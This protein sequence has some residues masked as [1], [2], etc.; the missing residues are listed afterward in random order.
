MTVF[1]AVV[2]VL[3]CALFL[4]GL[5]SSS[6]IVQASSHREAPLIIRDPLADDTD[7]YFFVSPDRPDMV[8]V[9][10]NWLP[11]QEPAGGPNFYPFDDNVLYQL[12]FDNDGDAVL[13]IA[14]EFRFRT[15]VINPDTFLYTTGRVD[16]NTLAGLNVRQTYSVTAVVVSS[17]RNVT[18][19]TFNRFLLADNLPTPP[20]NVGPRSTP[21]YETNYAERAIRNVP[22]AGTSG[23]NFFAGQ[24]DEGFFFDL[25]SGFD[26]FGLRPL[27]SLH[28]ISLPN[29]TGK[30]GLAG[31]NVN[32][33][34][35]QLPIQ[36]LTNNGTR[37]TD[38]TSP[39]AI[40]G[41]Y[42][43]ASRPRT[44]VLGTND[45]ASGGTDNRGTIS[46]NFA[47]DCGG[48]APSATCV[49]VSR[50]ANPLINELFIPQ[51]ASLTMPEND[52]DRYNATLPAQDIERINFI[53]GDTRDVE[54]V[55]LINMLYPSVNDA[56]T[57]G[58][59]DLVR[60]FLTGV[61]G[62]TRPAVQNDPNDPTAGPGAVPA[63]LIRLNLAVPPIAPGGSGYSRLGVIGGD[64]S[65]FPNGRRVADDVADIELRVL[66]GVLLPGNA[67]AGGTTPCNAAPNNQVTDGVDVND[68]PFRTT[69]PY[70]A[71]P[72]SGY[73]SPHSRT[74]TTTQP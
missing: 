46:G 27:N 12:R 39:A 38:P 51:G 55:A 49:Q 36:L 20:N 72:V 73:D 31:F 21:D 6:P 45:T 30:D 29:E 53:R 59:N 48:G 33:I 37:P 35:L 8:T 24:R 52:K 71:S 15:Q 17:P 70:L 64:M 44:T 47:A 56:P 67:C 2:T 58:R 66:A 9:I 32:T 11:F 57:R 54:P 7:V 19:R 43:T 65:G 18:P 13:D 28:V 68:R 63:D 74:S 42:A 62:A 3:C 40:I 25:G 50:L 1:S 41:V 10:G 16:P 14:L 61:P 60:V 23:I 34:A 26:L 22:F 5:P 69:F 4:T